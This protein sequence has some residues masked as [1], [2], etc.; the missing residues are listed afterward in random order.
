MRILLLNWRDHLSPRAG[1]AELLTYEVGRRLVERGHELTWFTSRPE[2]QPERETI[3]GISILRRGSETTTR[4]HARRALGEGRYDLVVEEVNTLPYFAPLWAR[5]P[6][7]FFINQLAREVWWYEAPKPVAA[8]GWLSEP[9]YLQAYR[10]TPTITISDSTR[11]DL[12]RLGLR[13]SIDVMPMAVN[14]APVAELQPKSPAGRLLAIGRLAPSKR[15]DHAIEALAELRRTHGD[16]SLTI[17]GEGRERE[18][19]E[20][21]ARALGVAAA[22]HLRGR[23]EEAEKTRLLTE[24]DILVGTSAREGWGL[25]VT[26]AAVRGTPSVVYDIPGFRDSVLD[27]GTGL[28]TPPKPSALA[29]GVRRLLDD[30]NLYE[31]LRA[32]AWR[33]AQELDWERTADVFEA[34][35]TAAAATTRGG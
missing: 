2:G 32:E 4:L 13:G 24:L 5:R 6:V 17:L 29:A 28:L 23:V 21:Q 7:L 15:Y 14:T 1:G 12:R 35:A 18:R 26:E 9:V 34:A 30:P 25:T 3:D 22:V 27:G 8:L 20:T 16:A 10:R 19:L 11:R 31:R 33:H